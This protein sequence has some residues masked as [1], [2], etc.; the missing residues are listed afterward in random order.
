MSEQDDIKAYQR[1]EAAQRVLDSEVYQQAW[2]DVKA[3]MLKEWENSPARDV[4]G[5]ERLHM[6]MACMKM[7]R[8]Y[9]EGYMQT[10]KLSKNRLAELDRRRMF[11][12]F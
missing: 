7:T 3:A 11:K 9:L 1:G 12:V 2:D 6:M 8:K 4:E 5:R 10:G